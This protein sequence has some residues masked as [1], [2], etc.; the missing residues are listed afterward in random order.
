MKYIFLM[1]KIIVLKKVGLKFC[2]KRL[3]FPHEHMSSG[4]L[5]QSLGVEIANALDP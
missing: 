1:T 2:L 5:F 4:S 3:R